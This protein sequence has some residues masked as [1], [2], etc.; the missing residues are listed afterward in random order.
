[1]RGF[2]ELPAG[3]GEMSESKV[4]P[5]GFNVDD[6]ACSLA[7]LLRKLRD[8]GVRVDG[9]LSFSTDLLFDFSD[10]GFLGPMAVVSLCLLRRVAAMQSYK[11]SLIKPKLER[12]DHYCSYSGLSREYELGEGPDPRHPRNVTRPVRVFQE[13][14]PQ[15]EISA[16][17]ELV[18]SKMH[19][20]DTGE[21]DLKLTL[22]EVARNVLDHAKSPIGGLISARAY[23][24]KREVR[25]A[26]ADA[27][28]GF[29]RTLQQR[30]PVSDDRDA[31][32]KVFQEKLSGRSQPHNMGQG[33]QHLHQVVSLTKG[34]LVVYS[35]GAFLERLDGKDRFSS[36]AVP[37]PGTIVFVRLPI[38]DDDEQDKATAGSFWDG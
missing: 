38:R 32:R 12:L 15:D 1:M 31:L 14:V 2:G 5:L 9:G 24:E 10:S 27:G 4:V 13:H 3:R 36:A 8:T 35:G 20:S 26:V 17:V 23:S 28:I 29:R 21:T 11:L 30:V 25:F 19:L 22:Y 7:M 34:S 18:K 33:L 6:T 37:F 16:V